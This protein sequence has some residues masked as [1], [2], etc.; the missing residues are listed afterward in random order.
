MRCVQAKN[1]RQNRICILA[2]NESMSEYER[3]RKKI[4]ELQSDLGQFKVDFLDR[5]TFKIFA[6]N[7]LDQVGGYPDVCMTGYFSETIREALE[8]IIGLGHRV[9]LICQEFDLNNKRDRKNLEVLKKLQEKGVEIRVNNRLHARFLV[10]YYLQK[11]GISGTLV[12]GSFDFNNECIGK[13]RHDA[14]IRTNNPDLVKASVDLFNKIWEDPE[15]E[16]FLKKY[17]LRTR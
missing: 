7:L 12:I 4:V 5:N 1:Y 17:V 15:S 16:F 11:N 10:A 8:R 13:E 2:W 3:F 6:D 9:R 14:G